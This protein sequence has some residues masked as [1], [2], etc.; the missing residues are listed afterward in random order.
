MDNRNSGQKGDN[1]NKISR[2]QFLKLL[3]AG[4]IGYFA[5]RAGFSNNNNNLFRNATAATGANML[6]QQAHT[7]TSSSAAGYDQ[8]GVKKIYHAVIF[9]TYLY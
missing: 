7:E 2:L 6:P 4:A 5:Y 3:G 8:F 9:S 1:N